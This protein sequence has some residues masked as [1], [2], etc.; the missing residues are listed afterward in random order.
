LPEIILSKSLTREKTLTIWMTDQNSTN[1]A[2]TRQNGFQR[3]K[4]QHVNKHARLFESG[5]GQNSLNKPQSLKA[6]YYAA[7]LKVNNISKAN[8]L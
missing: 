4:L 7:V 5:F 1:A 3:H 6:N 8:H 2:V